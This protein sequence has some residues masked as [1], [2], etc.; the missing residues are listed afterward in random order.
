LTQLVVPQLGDKLITLG[1]IHIGGPPA[2]FLDSFSPS[3]QGLLRILFAT[4]LAGGGLSMLKLGK[5]MLLGLRFLFALAF[6]WIRRFAQRLRRR[7]RP[8]NRERPRVI[9][10]LRVS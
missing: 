1:F 4:L 5:R 6:D 3:D 10:P 2:E 9:V 8:V 7:L